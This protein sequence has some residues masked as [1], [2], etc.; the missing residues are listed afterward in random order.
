MRHT[1]L[2]LSRQHIMSKYDELE[3]LARLKEQGILSEEEFQV[4]KKK[5]LEEQIAPNPTTPPAT[6][7]PE[8]R[9]PNVPLILVLAL[10]PVTI[11]LA[12][13]VFKS[14]NRDEQLPP[15]EAALDSLLST[16]PDTTSHT[17]AVTAELSAAVIDATIEDAMIRQIRR[18]ELDGLHLRRGEKL[19]VERGDLDRDGDDDI[20]VLFSLINTGTDTFIEYLVVCTNDGTGRLHI[21]AD[22]AAGIDDQTQGSSWNLKGI[23]NGRILVAVAEWGDA[24]NGE[25]VSERRESSTVREFALSGSR[26]TDVR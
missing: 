22:R 11:A 10:L 23:A 12:L 25:G 3:R 24:D 4:Q 26:I 20:A 19:E 9:K 13:W 21:A 18:A 16:V 8:K 7:A 5:V 17:P 2:Q 15:N 6:T 1:Q 14:G